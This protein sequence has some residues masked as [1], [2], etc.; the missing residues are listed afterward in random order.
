MAG[1]VAIGLLAAAVV[2]VVHTLLSVG[3]LAD[4][5]LRKY[6]AQLDRELDVLCLPARGQRL[7]VCHASVLAVVGIVSIA[8]SS[9]S[10]ALL[11][12]PVAV[13]PSLVLSWRRHRRIRKLEKQLPAWLIAMSN[14]LKASPSIGEALGSSARLMGGPIG[15]EVDLVLK[16]VALG[17][18]L[19][20]A[21]ADSDSRIGS[22]AF[23]S[24]AT[25]VRIG[26]QTGGEL[27]AILSRA[28]ET[29]REMERLQGVVRTRTAEAKTQSWA[30]AAI[31]FAVGSFLQGMDQNWF[32]QYLESPLGTVMLIAAIGL[33]VGSVLAA[34]KILS[35]DM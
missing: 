22:A 10:V 33:W 6:A 25:A 30:L 21:L 27:P 7:A 35:V 24:V 31:P 18:S 26:R 19:E 5:I 34:R 28:A 4:R 14:A 9:L 23:S 8:E 32:P 13:T 1:E 29:L 12:V 15:E 3:G 2:A 16:S 17:A 11:L 20:D